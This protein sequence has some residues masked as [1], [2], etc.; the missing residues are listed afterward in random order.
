MSNSSSLTA[1]LGFWGGYYWVDASLVLILG[2]TA[3][4]IGA[5][6]SS[7]TVLRHSMKWLGVGL[8][9]VPGLVLVSVVEGIMG[10]S[11]YDMIYS[12]GIVPWNAVAILLGYA[13]YRSARSLAPLNRLPPPN[14]R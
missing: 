12:Y 4:L 10:I 7:D 2:A 3:L 11:Y 9:C 6:R 14:L 1:V 5:R 8:L 13:L